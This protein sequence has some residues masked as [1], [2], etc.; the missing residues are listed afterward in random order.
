MQIQYWVLKTWELSKQVLSCL[1]GTSDALGEEDGQ[2]ALSR[3]NK[4]LQ[5]MVSAGKRARGEEGLPWGSDQMGR[6]RRS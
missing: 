1:W 6:M 4:Q 5:T 3:M 2:E